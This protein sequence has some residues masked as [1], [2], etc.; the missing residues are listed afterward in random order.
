MP[1]LTAEVKSIRA[2]YLA[3]F[4]VPQGSASPE[5][6]EEARQWSIRFAEQVAFERPG[7]GY[8]MKRADPTRPISKDTLSRQVDGQLLIW[9]LLTGT[10]TGHPSMVD[11]PDSQDVTGQTFSPVTPHAHVPPAPPLRPPAPN[12]TAVIQ[13]LDAVQ[14]ELAAVK[15][16]LSTLQSAPA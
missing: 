2:R 4:P 7:E 16:E 8:G 1:K 6:E 13:R 9:D 3:A 14:A 11:D 10:G 15:N 12:L 5:F